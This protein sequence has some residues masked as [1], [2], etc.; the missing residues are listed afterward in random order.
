MLFLPEA[1]MRTPTHRLSRAKKHHEK[2]T[3]ERCSILQ[4]V[5]IHTKE[6][7][8]GRKRKPDIIAPKQN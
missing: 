8:L 5:N 4:K 3:K 1:S 7:I 2:R 6:Y